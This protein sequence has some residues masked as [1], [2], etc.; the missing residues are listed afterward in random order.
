MVVL[1]WTALLTCLLAMPMGAVAQSSTS[2]PSRCLA[3]AQAAPNVMTVGYAALPQ[4]PTVLPVQE[5]TDAVRIRFIGHSMFLIESPEGVRIATDYFGPA[6]P[7]GPP[8]VVTMN[9]AHSTHY[10][11]SPAPAITHVLRGWNPQGGPAD[12]HLQVGDVVIR[13]VPTDIRALGAERIPDGNSIF[14]FELAGLCIGHLGHLHHVLSPED[15]AWLGQLDVV[16]VA[17][18]GSYT[19]SHAEVAKTLD[20]IKARL[21]LPMHYFGGSTLREF[22]G[23]LGED[24]TVEMSSEPEVIVSAATLPHTPK[25]LVLPGY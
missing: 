20:V 16:M 2:P 11:E 23:H 17:V 22:L 14:I 13:S 19:M 21:V 6:V 18:D 9:R 5:S 15:L 8:D 7:G 4:S 10:T 12:H 1:R 25:V 24:Y 3:V